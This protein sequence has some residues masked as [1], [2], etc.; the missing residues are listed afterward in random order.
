MEN[1]NEIN[2]VNENSGSIKISDEVIATI[3]S[4]AVSEID[5]VCGLMGSIAGELALKFGKK[6]VNK[7]IKVVSNDTEATI[8]ISLI[9]K[10]GI[11]IPEI[12]WEVQE[13]VKKSVESMSGLSV[14]KVNIH[15]AGVEF[16]KEDSGAEPVCEADEQE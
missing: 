8:D 10:Y 13:N 6:N 3:A 4:V 2:E 7:G 12:A 5:G 9:V 15:V 16:E 11:R 1:I 14:T